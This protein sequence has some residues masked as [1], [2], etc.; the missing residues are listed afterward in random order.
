MAKPINVNMR[1]L[2]VLVEVARR[3]SFRAAAAAANLGQ[4]GASQAISQLESALNARLLDRTTRSV[5]L[6]PAGEMFVADAERVLAD[7]DRSV[8]QLDTFVAKG[9]RRVRVACL[10]S[11][12]FRL[13][14][15]V[16]ARIATEHPQ[17]SVALYDD[18]VR[19]IR[20]R[21]ES[22]QC[23]VGIASEDVASD[24]V[25]FEPL[26]DDPFHFFGPVGHPLSGSTPMDLARAHGH[27]LILLHKDSNIRQVIDRAL[28]SRGIVVEVAHET[29][30]MHTLV[31][32]VEA[33]MGA[34]IIPAMACA[35]TPGRTFVRPLRNPQILR[36]VGLCFPTA[37]P[38]EKSAQVFASVFRESI[39]ARAR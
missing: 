11:A 34:S 27:A 36:R 35:S 31:G 22:G 33:G 12:V 37:R 32:M 23:D 8:E 1:H 29:S 24:S 25:G 6:T 19:G 21:I 10:S 26:L 17:L 18:S 14:P 20:R 15:E 16:L 3:K 39:A 5:A 30:Q 7:F 4:P 38:F 13:L 2:R 28:D 9:K